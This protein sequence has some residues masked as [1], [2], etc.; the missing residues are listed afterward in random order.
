MCSHTIQ[1]WIIWVWHWLSRWIDKISKC[2]AVV[3]GS[4]PSSQLPQTSGVVQLACSSDDTV[5]AAW[6]VLSSEKK[7]LMAI[8]GM[9]SFKTGYRQQSSPSAC[10]EV[11]PFLQGVVKY[12]RGGVRQLLGP[13][14]SISA[15]KWGPQIHSSPCPST[16]QGTEM[17]LHLTLSLYKNPEQRMSTWNSF[18][19]VVIIINREKVSMHI[20]IS[21]HHFQVGY[22]MNVKN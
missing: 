19:E 14:F 15:F 7:G 21:D 22:V 18:E 16:L 17:K 3:L 6:G 9:L 10:P 12:L 13:P 8:L 20:S 11:M 2:E 4:P 5:L 1:A